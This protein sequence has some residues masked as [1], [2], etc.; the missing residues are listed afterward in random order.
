MGDAV[1]GFS[2]ACECST[3]GGAC[4]KCRQI[5]TRTFQNTAFALT[6]SDNEGYGQSQRFLG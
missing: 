6:R 5:E 3:M 2:N 4:K 1:K